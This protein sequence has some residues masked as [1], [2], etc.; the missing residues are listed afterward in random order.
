MR[1]TALSFGAVSVVCLLLTL[2]IGAQIT[3]T[4]FASRYGLTATFDDATNL[5]SGNPVR[6]AGVQVGLVRGV[7][8]VEGRARVNFAVDNDVILPEDTEV[9]VRWLNLLG[10]R[11]LYLYPGTSPRTL[12]HGSA[13]LRTRS[14][15]DLGQLINQ[16]G[17]LTQALDP[18]QVNQLLETLVAGLDGNIGNVDNVVADLRAVLGTLASRNE[19]IGQLIH[20]YQTLT[21]AVAHRDQQIRTA[22]D[23]LVALSGAFAR[24]DQVLDDS[25]VD[26]PKLTANLQAFLSANAADLGRIIDNLSVVTGV[27]HRRLGDLE[28]TLHDLPPAL[29]DLFSVT[30]DG[31]FLN[32]NLVC[33]SPTRSPCPHPIILTAAVPG[34]GALVNPASFRSALVGGAS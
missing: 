4:G 14:V 23:N 33:L 3:H 6:L 22:V 17:P 32:I 18:K 15:V 16:L 20:D 27:A 13:V 19:T 30:A 25:L 31:R 24:S 28:T 1:R 10:Q 5:H 34:A 11:E 21:A 2:Y 7:K 26:L 9:A 8:L 12:R 29:Q